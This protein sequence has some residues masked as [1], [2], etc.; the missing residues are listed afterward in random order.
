MPPKTVEERL[1]ELENKVAQLLGEKT[2]IL[3]NE[4]AAQLP[5]WLHQWV[6]A[7]KDDPDF[8]A[9]MERGAEYR[10]SQPDAADEWDAIVAERVRSEKD[11]ASA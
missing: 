11:N 4:E 8:D 10:R 3:G 1:T 7:F 5:A 6:G 2:A 9:A